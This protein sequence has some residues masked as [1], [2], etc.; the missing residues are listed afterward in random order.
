MLDEAMKRVSEEVEAHRKRAEHDCGTS[1]T[2]TGVDSAKHEPNQSQNDTVCAQDDDTITTLLMYSEE[3]HPVGDEEVMAVQWTDVDID[4]VLDSGCSDHVMNIEL[5][6]PGY[7]VGPSEGSKNGRGFI[8]GNGERVPNEGQASI[9]LRSMG[10]QG[11]LVDFRSVFQSAKVIRP[12]MSVAKI[13]QNGYSC[14]FT[15]TE[16]AVKDKEG[17][18]VCRFRREGGI[19]VS[20]LKL[21]APTPFTRPA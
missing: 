18:V 2:S 3:D 10:E 4:V 19:Y 16:A 1:T 15:A 12:L 8:V 6:A 20:R 9:N 11:R 7:P 17:K 5:D 14:A 13:C 21:R